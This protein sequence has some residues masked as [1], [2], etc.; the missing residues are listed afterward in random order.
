MICGKCGFRGSTTHFKNKCP[1]CPAREG[2]Y[3]KTYRARRKE[4]QGKVL[5]VDFGGCLQSLPCQHGCWWTGEQPGTRSARTIV[6]KMREWG[7]KVPAHFAEQEARW[8]ENDKR[9]AERKAKAA[10]ASAAAAP[11]P[12][13]APQ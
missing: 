6:A 13:A 10:A 9:R 7:I 5:H 3:V 11:A 12:A 4:H 8:L 2:K 1:I